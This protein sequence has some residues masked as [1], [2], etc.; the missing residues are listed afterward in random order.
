[1]LLDYHENG[2]STAQ[3]SFSDVRWLKNLSA[4]PKIVSIL[5]IFSKDRKAVEDFIINIYRQ[6]YGAKIG[7]HYPMLMSV[8]ND[9][10]DILAASGFRY[11]SQET[12][13]LEQYLP[14]PIETMLS[15]PR[16][17]IV[18]IGNL[19]SAGGGA[20]M[21]L[22]AAL[23]AYLDHKG[24]THAA[25]TG[26]SYIEKR[27]RS[28][29][30]KPQSLAPADPKKLNRNDEDWGTYYDTDPHVFSGHIQEGYKNLQRVL[31]AHY[32]QR[33]PR[34]HMRLHYREDVS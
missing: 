8:T 13:F 14:A 2:F 25:I 5:P 28:L 16:N 29:G 33:F 3:L 20:S 6:S 18:E 31:G 34:L 1:M 24:L 10:G 22:F 4:K 11:A 9:A 23:S 19:A 30:L 26:T 12:L 7:I 15:A 32:T 21:F 27:L 17:R